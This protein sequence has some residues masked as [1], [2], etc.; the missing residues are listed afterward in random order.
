M[1][2][3]KSVFSKLIKNFQLREL[4]NQLGWNHTT[5]KEPV[6]VDSQ[7]YQLEAIAEKSAF[8]V[9][10]CETSG[11]V[12]DYATRKKIDS[13][14]T[15][16]YHQHLIIYTNSGKRQQVWQ[17]VV[18]ELDKPAV[19]RETPYFSTQ[20]PEL[21]L[22]KLQHLFFTID[23]EDNITI[24]DVTG[25]IGG[26]FNTNAEK[27]T[28]K[29][30]E[31]F[32]KEHTAFLSF[33]K[34]IT[35]SQDKD[36]YASLMLN[37]LMFIYFIQKKGFL[38]NDKFYLKTKLAETQSRKG[39]DNFYSFYRNFLLVL[40]HQGLGSPDNKK[41]ENELGKVPYLN[42]G[43]FDVHELETTY[44][45]IQIEDKAFERIFSF[46]DEYEWHLDTRQKATG[47]EINPD[48]I[49]YIFEKYI[50]D[51]AA[52]GAYYTK[53]D[54][55]DYIGKNCIIP[56]LF[57][58]LKR[59][60]PAALN[61]GSDVWK[62]LQLHTSDYIY[63]AIQHGVE[64]ELPAEI[65]KGLGDVSQRGEWNKPAPTETGYALPTE[66]WRE[67][68]ERRR[69]Y[70]EVKGKIEAGEIHEIN[71]LITYNLNITKF[72]ID[73]IQNRADPEL[74]RHFY[75][76]LEKIT[77][78]D[79]TCGS[80]AF[81]FAAMNILEP[82][83]E[84]CIG[85][86]HAF[87]D[88]GGTGKFKIFD[89]VLKRVDAPEHPNLQY[90][91][92]K[93]IIL[94][95]LFGVDI[96]HEAIEIAKLRLFL[97][98]VATVDVD[99]KK[100][101][102]G[103]EPLPDIDFNIRSG[104]S[105]VG[106]VSIDEVKKAVEGQLGFHD[107]DIASIEEGADYVKRAFSAFREAQIEND[108]TKKGA[109]KELA[110]RLHKLNNRLDVYL[111]KLYGKDPKKVSD[112]KAWHDSH[113]P[114][115][116]FAE[117]YEIIHDRGGFDVIIGNPPYLEQREVKYSVKG[118]VTAESG[119]IHS[120]CVERSFN[121]TSK[122][123]SISMIVPLALV[124]T[125]RMLSTQNV[126][127]STSC[128]WYSNFS[129]RPGKLFDTVN[130]ALTIFISRKTDSNRVFSTNY[131]KWNAHS[132]DE[133]MNQISYC[134]IP[135]DR[136]TSW[137][138]KIGNKTEIKILEKLLKTGSS[139][140]KFY[141]KSDNRVYYR[142]TGGLYWKI[143]T[144][145]APKFVLNG[146]KGHSS[147]ETWFTLGTKSHIKSA[148]AVLSS[149]LFW[150]WY[151]VTSNLRDLNPYDIQNFPCLESVLSDKKIQK[152]GEQYLDDLELNSVM[153]ERQQKTTGT[154]QTQSFKI[155]KSK[156]L[157]DQ[158]D[159]TLAAHYGLNDEELDFIIN[160]DIKYRMGIGAGGD[161]DAE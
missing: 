100:S 5:K 20:E 112:Y 27:V 76:A 145:F 139:I 151:T 107:K 47:K 45:T 152:L 150:W 74:I 142:T 3:K 134:E 109:K 131:K 36:W 154:T 70:A 161:E 30:Y 110:D 122:Y 104:N 89:E 96:M 31:G 118:F 102:M 48:V 149:D 60:Y 7:V 140:G 144:D 28:K 32:K 9:F 64:L 137:R 98:L 44:T 99:Y 91:I 105:L 75:K 86:M 73:V 160:Y 153:L 132:R 147:R 135:H 115:H 2:I 52:M 128:A 55:T 54:I 10:V 41:L 22:Q 63:P 77:V 94:N 39:K 88:E 24:A 69:R 130:R 129:W 40:F 138:P 62:L 4:F 42:G 57:D 25:R 71:D 125:Q 111:G 81:L 14:I 38:N 17:L 43:L 158:I 82:L 84:A 159:A 146:K 80:G 123:A 13:A 114:F 90:F 119:A 126:I 141:G 157:L 1:S 49:G 8:F 72:A 155:Q 108:T 120:M 50:N 93:T 148:V 6:A 85:R 78:L 116:W 95:N 34:G 18:K 12:P 136:H 66:I 19:V 79:P 67:V 87:V 51:R 37:R 21:L 59:H 23:E 11:K 113:Q 15:K 35:E 97:K 46:F 26:A 29:F 92:F 106:F 143:F 121:V 117:F 83:Y 16:L 61:K 103:L 65:A 124:S 58:E 53:E 33:I 56:F 133:L 156:E 127:E 68:V 101:N